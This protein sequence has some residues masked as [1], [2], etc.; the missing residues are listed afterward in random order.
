MALETFG[1]RLRV[2]RIDKDLSQIALRDQ[3]ETVYGVSIGE[4]Y[5][6]ELERTAYCPTL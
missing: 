6:S 2:S 3:M 1:K 4:T 5:I